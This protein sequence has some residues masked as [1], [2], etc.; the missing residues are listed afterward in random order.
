MHK[1]RI[2][3]MWTCSGMIAVMASACAVAEDKPA[4]ETGPWNSYVGISGGLGALP[5]L[6]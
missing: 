4:V 1:Q 2:T 3:R 6:T 5:L